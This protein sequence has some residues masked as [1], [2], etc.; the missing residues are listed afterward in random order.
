MR[1][2]QGQFNN[3]FNP[4]LKLVSS[5]RFTKF[6]KGEK[7]YPINME[8]S[9]SHVCNAQCSWCFYAGTHQKSRQPGAFMPSQMLE[10]LIEDMKKLDV[11]ALSWTGGGEPTLHPDFPERSDQAYELGLKQGMFTNALSGIDYNPEHFD[12]IRV[13]N[14]NHDWNVENLEK[15]R[16]RTKILG[17]AV[18]YDGDDKAVKHALDIGKFVG[19]DYVQVRQALALRGLVTDREPPK[20]DDPRLFIT[21]YKFDDSA[22]PHGYEQCYGFNFAPF[23]WSNGNVDVCGYH[24]TTGEPYTLGNLSA[25]PLK[26]ILD[27]APR[28]VQVRDDCQVCCKNHEINKVVDLSSKLTD[29]DFV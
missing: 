5:E 27:E 4:Q 2:N 13:S 24:R 29:K 12:W 8:V 6:M 20:I 16:E 19:V 25:K 15:L 23:V 28:S 9:P 10:T 21:T 3:R 22:N 17:M 11:K 26:Q 18:N 7:V 14:T 1:E